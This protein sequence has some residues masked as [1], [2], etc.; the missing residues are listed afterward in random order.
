MRSLSYST[1]VW[2]FDIYN[3]CKSSLVSSSYS[4][5]NMKVA[6]VGGTG[7]TGSIIV[8]AL[9]ESDIPALVPFFLNFIVH[10]I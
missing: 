9:L 5:A 8:N 4:K 1:E 2:L 3:S 7:E 6:L 10:P